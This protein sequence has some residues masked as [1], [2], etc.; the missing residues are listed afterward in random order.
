MLTLHTS[1][2][3][4]RALLKAQAT[5]LHVHVATGTNTTLL[6]MLNQIEMEI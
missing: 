3:T 2:A 6:G 4:R 5:E 1:E